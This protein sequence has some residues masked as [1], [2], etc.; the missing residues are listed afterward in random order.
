MEK[1]I[2]LFCLFFNER[3]TFCI[4]SNHR[5][6][7]VEGLANKCNVWIACGYKNN[8]RVYQSTNLKNKKVFNITYYKNKLFYRIIR[9]IK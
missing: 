8:W 7:Y 4:S 9:E 1:I 5:N 3:Y 6:E 2:Q